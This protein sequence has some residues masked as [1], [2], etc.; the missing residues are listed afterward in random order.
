VRDAILLSGWTGG[1]IRPIV[2]ANPAKS[3]LPRRG[4]ESFAGIVWEVDGVGRTKLRWLDWICGLATG[5]GFGLLISWH[6]VLSLK[7]FQFVGFHGY[8]SG[9]D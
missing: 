7:G 2:H 1:L 3:G 4:F 8:P 5:L 9:V 6:G